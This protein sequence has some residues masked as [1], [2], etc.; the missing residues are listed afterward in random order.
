[1]TGKKYELAQRVQALPFIGMGVKC[2]DF[3]R[4]TGFPRSALYESKEEQLR[5]NMTQLWHL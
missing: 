2:E 3:G 4:M 5:E 1:M